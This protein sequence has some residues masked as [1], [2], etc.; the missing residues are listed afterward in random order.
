MP[1]VTIE[2]IVEARTVE[3]FEYKFYS[4]SNGNRKAFK[5]EYVCKPMN[6]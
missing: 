5:V 6:Y 4:E 2:F 3:E 1:E